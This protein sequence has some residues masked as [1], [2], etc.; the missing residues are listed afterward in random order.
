MEQRKLSKYSVNSNLDEDHPFPYP[1]GHN[2]KDQLGE[3]WGDH[4]ITIPIVVGT[5][6]EVSSTLM[7][8]LNNLPFVGPG[9]NRLLERIQRAAV[10]GTNLIL[11]QHL[12]MS[13]DLCTGK[14][15]SEASRTQA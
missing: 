5:C 4:I 14:R 11:C 3:L 1:A 15:S 12:G 8:H 7:Q 9:S 2:L 6:G 10:E 13:A